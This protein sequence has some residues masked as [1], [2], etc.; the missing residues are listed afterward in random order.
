MPFPRQTRLTRVSANH[1]AVVKQ[2]GANR[3]R[4]PLAHDRGAGDCE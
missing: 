2:V 3:S 4:L 1:T